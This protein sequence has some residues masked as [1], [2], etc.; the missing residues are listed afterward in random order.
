MEKSK[1]PVILKVIHHRQNPLE[2][3][4]YLICKNCLSALC[5]KGHGLRVHF[6]NRMIYESFSVKICHYEIVVALEF[7]HQVMWTQ[8]REHIVVIAP[9]IGVHVN[10]T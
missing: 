4:N 1:N 8:K 9:C 7:K 2:S 6:L 10:N 3:T 5:E